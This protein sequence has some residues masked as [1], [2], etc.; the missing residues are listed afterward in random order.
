MN[1]T[2][3]ARFPPGRLV[4]TLLVASVALWAL[5]FFVTLPHLRLLA[6]GAEPFDVRPQG[7]S[8]EEARAFLTA[9][10]A[11]GRAY[12][13]NPELLLDTF[14]PLLFAVSRA[15]A[16]WWLTMPGRLRPG[17]TPGGI[18]WTLIGVVAVE[19]VL[20]FTENTCIAVMIWMWPD[21]SPPLV[22]VSSLATRLKFL[23]AAVTEI[24]MIVLAA[25][26]LI[27]RLRAKK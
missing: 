19:T 11:E 2:G 7:Y 26:A 20:D 15:L 13:L 22:L 3:I 27:R 21:L 10:G 12:Y 6:G 25:A 5:L 24:S 17:A 8:Y 16:L 4:I 9:I 23:A 14:Y 18:R 1:S